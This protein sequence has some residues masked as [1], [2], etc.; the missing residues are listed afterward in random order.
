MA[1]IRAPGR[2]PELGSGLWE[3]TKDHEVCPW[4]QDG[5]RAGSQQRIAA[6]GTAAGQ[7]TAQAGGSSAWGPGKEP[8][9][10]VV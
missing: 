3:L 7:L 10:E 8:G 4:G 6:G 1:W 5:A 9:L 2:N